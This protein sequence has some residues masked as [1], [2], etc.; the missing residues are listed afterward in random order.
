VETA[1]CSTPSGPGI[2]LRQVIGGRVAGGDQR[3]VC[4]MRD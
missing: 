1:I 3:M 2:D 4:I